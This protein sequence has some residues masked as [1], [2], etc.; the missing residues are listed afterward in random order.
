MSIYFDMSENQKIHY[1]LVCARARNGSIKDEC[2]MH[3][4]AKITISGDI[5]T[6]SFHASDW[7]DSDCTVRT[8]HNGIER[9]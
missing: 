8:F 6:M 5:I 1:H 4:N 3:V 2:T 9:D 7:Y